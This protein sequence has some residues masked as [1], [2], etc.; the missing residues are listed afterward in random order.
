MLKQIRLR[1]LVNDIQRFPEHFYI[2]S[3]WISLTKRG[4]NYVLFV[5]HWK[6]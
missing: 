3:T 6:P 5:W 4:Q 2:K 1:L